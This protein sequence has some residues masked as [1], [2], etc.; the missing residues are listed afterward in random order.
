MYKKLRE[1]FAFDGTE[2][3]YLAGRIFELYAHLFNGLKGHED[4]ILKIQ[5]Y[6][7]TN[8]NT[9]CDVADIAAVVGLERHYLARLFR[10]K[11]GGTLKDYITEKR[12]EEAKQ[13][14]KSGQTVGNAAQMVGYSDPFVFSKMFKKRFGMPPGEWKLS[15]SQNE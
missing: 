5:N 8:Y 9:Q 11:T 13:L 7:E 12:M 3:E 10:Q 14:L 15:G 2:E 6:V 4:Y 1:V